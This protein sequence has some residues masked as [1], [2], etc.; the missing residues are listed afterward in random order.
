MGKWTTGI[1]LILITVYSVFVIIDYHTEKKD[2]N[3]YDFTISGE[4][5]L[6]LNYHRV[7]SSN[8]LIKPL[9]KLTMTYSG[10][11]ELTVYSIYED[12]FKEQ[13]MYLKNKGFRFIEPNELKRYIRYDETLPKKC[14]LITF[15]DGDVSI[16]KNAYPFLAEEGIPFTLFI[17]TGEVGNPDFNG[18]ELASW[19]QI[20]EM[21]NSG[22]ATIGTH[23][24]RMHYL[25][26]SENPPFL[27]LNKINDFDQ[28]TQLTIKTIEEKLGFTPTY[29]AYPYGFGMPQTDE[30]LLESGYELVFTLSP[31]L[32]KQGD[33]S[34]FIKRVLISRHTWSNVVEWIR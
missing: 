22:F 13:I 33:P 14:A 4:G 7:R 12:E 24:H 2:L 27:S 9:D 17:I 32:V 18:L 3:P 23:T 5:C 19:N 20:K 15:D 10:D 26:K 29:Y 11:M 1:V 16:Y 34:F 8:Y 6:I 21:R 30:I 25:D 31:G 28:D